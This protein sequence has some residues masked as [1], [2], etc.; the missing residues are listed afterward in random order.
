MTTQKR[1]M[2]TGLKQCAVIEFLTPDNISP[3]EIY[4][5]L[6]AVYES[7]IADRT[8]V[9]RWALR[10]RNPEPGKLNISDELCSGRRIFA[11]DEEHRSRD[12]PYSPELATCDFHLF[13]S[14]KRDLKGNRYAN[15]EEVKAAVYSWIR[16]Q[17]EEFLRDGF[18]KWVLSVG[19]AV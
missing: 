11:S 19:S 9:N 6:Q 10:S 8:T 1:D 7:E 12:P 13:P 2:C 4:R 16:N 17:P 5:R 15:N 3:T 14:L 18:T